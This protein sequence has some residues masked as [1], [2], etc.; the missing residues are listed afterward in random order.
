MTHWVSLASG[1]TAH[2]FREGLR[3]ALD[4]WPIR[5]LIVILAMLNITASAYAVLLLI[6]VL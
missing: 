5:I 2:V 1:S 4:N 3:Y 6:S